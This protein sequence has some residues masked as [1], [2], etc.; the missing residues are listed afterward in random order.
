M[1]IIQYG[2][3]ENCDDI[4]QKIIINNHYIKAKH[5]L[6]CKKCLRD[7]KIC[8][9]TKSK[10]I[11]CLIDDDIKNVKF[12]YLENNKT[13]QFYK[14]TDIETIVINKYGSFDNLQKII[15]TKNETKKIKNQK[16]EDTKTQREQKIKEM[17]QNNKLEFKNYGDAYS[18]IHY[19]KPALENV[20]QN[21]LNKNKQKNNRRM[22]LAKELHKLNIPLDETLNSCY[23]YINNINNKPIEDVVRHIEIE[24]FLKHKTDYDQLRKKYNDTTAKEIAIRNYAKTQQLPQNINNSYK[25]IKIDFY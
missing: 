10:T 14:Y 13:H 6:F 11:F 12:I 22:M 23:E 5:Y 1:E 16:K 19:G 4:K 2:I 3:C 9:K 21:E 20:I 7:M 18:Y 24:N 8:S 25:N 17:F 15:N